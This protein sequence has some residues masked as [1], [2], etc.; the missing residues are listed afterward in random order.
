MPRSSIVKMTS[1]RRS[2]TLRRISCS[3]WNRISVDWDGAEHHDGAAFRGGEDE[4]GELAEIEPP[5]GETALCSAR[6][7]VQVVDIDEDTGLGLVTGK[8]EILRC[9]AISAVV[10]ETE[11]VVPLEAREIVERM[12]REGVEAVP[13]LRRIEAELQGEI[14]GRLHIRRVLHIPRGSPATL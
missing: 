12:E 10:D 4:V 13:E 5:P 14:E 11:A 2:A 7:G 1:R 8:T 6:V 3:P 9:E